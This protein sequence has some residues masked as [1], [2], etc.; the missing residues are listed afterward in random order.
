MRGAEADKNSLLELFVDFVICV[1]GLTVIVSL[2]CSLLALFKLGLQ[3]MTLRWKHMFVAMIS[4][5]HKN[6]KK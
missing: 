3:T 2:C 5:R 1:S 4:C 6:V